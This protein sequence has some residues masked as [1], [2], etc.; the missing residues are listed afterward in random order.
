M[1]Q[2]ASPRVKVYTT[3]HT[4]EGRKMIAAAVAAPELL[5]GVRENKARLAQLADPLPTRD[6]GTQEI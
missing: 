6:V 4:E 5:A 2:A 1:L 3:G